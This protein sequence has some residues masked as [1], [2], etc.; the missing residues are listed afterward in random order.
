MSHRVIHVGKLLNHLDMHDVRYMDDFLVFANERNALN[1]LRTKIKDFLTRHL[2]I[3][4]HEPKSQIY[5]GRRGITFLGLRLCEGKRRLA[6]RNIRR[7]RRRTKQWL[8]EMRLSKSPDCAR[9]GLRDGERSRTASKKTSW[10]TFLRC[11]FAHAQNADSVMLRRWILKKLFSNGQALSW[12]VSI[13]VFVHR[14]LSV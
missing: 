5:V 10:H 11:W 14:Y 4:L 3:S 1:Q 6:S 12:I 13:N 2:R 8:W 9:D 7:M